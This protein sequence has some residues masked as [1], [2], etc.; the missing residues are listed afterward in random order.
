MEIPVNSPK[1]QIN[2]ISNKIVAPI[3]IQIDDDV[4]CQITEELFASIYTS[5]AIVWEWLY[6]S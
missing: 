5:R 4:Y 1:K 6:E 2:D 3:Q